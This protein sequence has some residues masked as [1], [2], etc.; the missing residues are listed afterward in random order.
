MSFKAQVRDRMPQPP[1]VADQIPFDI[2]RDAERFRQL[3]AKL[4]YVNGRFPMGSYFSLTAIPQAG[5]D[6]TL[7]EALDR[8]L[9]EERGRVRR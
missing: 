6:E 7:G 1:V 8:M 9:A 5:P 3:E 2:L 4:V